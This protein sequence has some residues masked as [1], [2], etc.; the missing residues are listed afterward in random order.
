MSDNFGLLDYEV[1]S[2][3]TVH[4]DISVSEQLELNPSKK[5]SQRVSASH[6]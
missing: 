4:S 5:N 2:G 3:G 1:H 6:H